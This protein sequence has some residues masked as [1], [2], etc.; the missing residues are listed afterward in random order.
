MRERMKGS[1]AVAQKIQLAKLLEGRTGSFK[2]ID[3][4]RQLDASS[5][6]M[7]HRTKDLLEAKLIRRRSR[8]KFQ[9]NKAL[10]RNEILSAF[11]G[12]GNITSIEEVTVAPKKAVWVRAMRC[13]HCQTLIEVPLT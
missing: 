3:L 6:W 5:T 8:T 12:R 4:L 9:P 2:P 10:T 11:N 1:Q 13:P 7:H